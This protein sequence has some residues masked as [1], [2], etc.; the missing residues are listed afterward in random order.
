MSIFKT[1]RNDNSLYERAIADVAV[2]MQNH[3]SVI[4]DKALNT[5]MLGLEDL[6]DDQLMSV[7]RPA[8]EIM[9][10]LRTSS[11]VT[12]LAD[13]GFNQEQISTG[14]EH[15][16]YQL[17]T[18]NTGSKFYKAALTKVSTTGDTMEIM[19]NDEDGVGLESFDPI[20]IEDY[21]PATI[22]AMAM[23]RN[24]KFEDMFFPSQFVPAGSSGYDLVVKMPI[25]YSTTPRSTNGSK[26]A[27]VQN[28]L[29]AAVIDPSIL[30][31][32]QTTL[33]PYANDADADVTALLVPASQI[34][35]KH[36]NIGSVAVPTRPIRFSADPDLI[37]LSS[38]PGLLA[39][40]VYDETDQL[41]PALNIGVVSYMLTIDDGVG[42]ASTKTAF[43]EY[44]ISSIQMSQ[45]Y[46]NAAGQA[47]GYHTNVSAP[48]VLTNKDA[49]VNGSTLAE[50]NEA[51]ANAYGLTLGQ[52]FTLISTM[53]LSANA[54][55]AD[56]HM[57]V[58][59]NEF[60]LTELFK[61]DGTRLDAQSAIASGTT[62]TITPLGWTP[63]ARRTNANMR[64]NGIIVDMN[65]AYTYRMY[66]TLSAPIISQTP[67]NG[68][69]VITLD[70]LTATAKLRTSGRC[71]D[72][73][74]KLERSLRSV[75]GLS[76]AE[77]LPGERAGVKPTYVKRTI[78][79]QNEVSTLSSRENIPALQGALSS[80]ITLT[81]NQLIKQ[82]NY[83]P[84]LEANNLSQ[85]AFELLMVT[86]YGIE[87]IL[88]TSG[89]LRTFG[90]NRAYKIAGS[91]NKH[92]DG[93]IYLTLGLKT[94]GEVAHPLHFGRLLETPS[95]TYKGDF[96]RN[97]RT[98]TEV[99]TVVR[100]KPYV[101]LPVLGVIDVVGM[102]TL[103]VTSTD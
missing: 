55:T 43:Y 33:I 34:P 31:G 51:I 15:A 3:K 64:S 62:I 59:A 84:A 46:Q 81:F 88:M 24:T 101:F 39:N 45:L 89:D 102:D 8:N 71:V 40:S 97:G 77:K 65:V 78:N 22:V 69:N 66:L 30:E 49:P 26:F 32:E 2:V 83:I 68:D 50:I 27:I 80:A 72:E 1:T 57:Q 93:K 75:S 96:A 63:K 44:D 103:F 25:I 4:T 56:S 19:T 23:T 11:L 41:D 20:T 86:D 29:V 52:R 70:G 14:L 53:S 79:V 82:S 47:Q 100:A 37:S 94:P 58:F 99:H 87:P 73:L 98:V 54:N 7:S 13:Q 12:L 67:V 5:S 95:L 28:P 48:I 61:Q 17:M 16:A 91:S 90:E 36:V 35:T 74:L 42:G 9:N 10:S 76:F 21:L 6:N 18:Y 85:D 60:K 38:H 92:F